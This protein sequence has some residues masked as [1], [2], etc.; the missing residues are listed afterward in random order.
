RMGLTQAAIAIYGPE[1]VLDASTVD[2]GV[3]PTLWMYNPQGLMGTLSQF[4]DYEVRL[5]GGAF[6]A[7]LSGGSI[8]PFN[9]TEISPEFAQVLNFGIVVLA[10]DPTMTIT[11]EGH[12][13]SD[14]D[15]AYNLNLSQSRADAVAAYFIG[16]GISA[17]RVSAVGIGEAEP[18]ASNDTAEGRSRNRR[19]EFTLSSNA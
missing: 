14:G 4:P 8:F 16:G 3:S 13:D 19:V 6:S 1:N 17:D 10:R 11:I 7:S 9:S 15:D 5:D 12:T 18:A 2:A